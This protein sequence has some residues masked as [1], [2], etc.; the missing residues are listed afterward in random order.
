MG[1]LRLLHL[2]NETRCFAR[3]SSATPLFAFAGQFPAPPA[4]RT[5]AV[6]A[7]PRLPRFIVLIAREEADFAIIHAPLNRVQS[8]ASTTLVAHAGRIGG[9][10][11]FEI[12]AGAA[13]E[14][15]RRRAVWFQRGIGHIDP[16]EL[17]SF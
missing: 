13:I 17:H 4:D 10:L 2:I 8:R 16:R 14:H 6:V 7:A 15:R 3:A 9:A 11:L 12:L 1:L 5:F